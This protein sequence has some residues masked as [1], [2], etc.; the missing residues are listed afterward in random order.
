MAELLTRK[1]QLAIKAEAA[2]G[3]WETDLAT[4]ANA[5]AHAGNLLR[6]PSWTP[7]ALMFDRNIVHPSLTSTPMFKPGV[8]TLELTHGFE[9]AGHE[10]NVP[11]GSNFVEPPIGPALAACG[12]IGSTVVELDMPNTFTTGVRFQHG[13]TVTGTSLGTAVVV[14]DCVAGVDSTIYLRDVSGTATG[15]AITGGTT[16]AVATATGATT[17]EYY[18]FYPSSDQ[19]SEITTVSLGYFIDGKIVEAAGCRGNVEFSFEHGNVPVAN[20]TWQGKINDVIDGALMSGADAPDILHKT[21][22]PFLGVGFTFI[23]QSSNTWTPV[24]NSMSINLGNSVTLRENSNSSTGYSYASITGRD[25]VL[26]INPDEELEAAWSVHDKMKGPS[27]LGQTDL[28][29]CQAR[30]TCGAII[31]NTIEFR[32]PAA[33]LREASETDRDEVSAWDLT[34]GL[35]GGVQTGSNLGIDNELVIIFR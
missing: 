12:M 20:F 35:T 4:A 31:G 24:F 15:E 2:A 5:K 11:A 16:G 21:P 13:E 19:V 23:D 8:T 14:G 10:D 25:A 29:A 34:C 26:G 28:T 7:S 6:S 30:F 22:P 32:S 33:E 3:T 18:A 17:Q 9:L 1:R 27:S